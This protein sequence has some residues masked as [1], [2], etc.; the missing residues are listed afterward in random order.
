M[1]PIKFVQIMI[2]GCDLLYGKKIF[3]CGF[4]VEYGIE[5]YIQND[6][7]WVTKSNG[8]SMQISLYI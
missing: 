7:K 1:G 6:K 2:L 4:K 8:R 3:I 5:P